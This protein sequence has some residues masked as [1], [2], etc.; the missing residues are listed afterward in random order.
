MGTSAQRKIRFFTPK[1]AAKGPKIGKHSQPVASKQPK[2]AYR[3]T[4]WPAYNQALIQRGSLQLWLDQ[5]T[6]E[7]WYFTGPQK[8]GGAFRYSQACIECAL[9]VKYVL[10]LA[11][12]QT[13]GFLT[14]L[15]QTLKLDLKIPSYTQLCRRQAQLSQQLA[16]TP[17]ASTDSQAVYLVVDSTGVK[18]YGEGEWKVRQHGSSKRR[19]W[20]KVHIAY[21]EA[22]N[23]VLAIALTS[24]D[25]DDASMLQPLLEELTIPVNRVAADGAYDQKKVYAYLQQQQIQAIIP[26][27]ANAIL[28]T[29]RQ[30]R[31]LVHE[32]NQAVL[33]IKA[34]GLAEWKWQVGYHR[35]S[36]AETGMYRLKVI[37]G[38]RLRS[39]GLASQQVEVRIKADCLNQFCRLGMPMAVKKPPT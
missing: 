2:T 17:A 14:S 10:G 30:G 16:P 27:R 32:R 19:S 23:Q 39:R 20:R 18:M 38:E 28:W 11:F 37:F 29:D 25:V 15:L 35:R 3:L 1:Q 13:Q 36:K 31:L 9:H 4:N 26:P 5:Q 24:S 12:R 6:L 7:N 34:L 33:A 21:D 22:T 8:P